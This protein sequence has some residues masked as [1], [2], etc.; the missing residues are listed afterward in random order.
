[1][2]SF[3]SAAV[4]LVALAAATP[5]FAVP[6]TVSETVTGFANG[7]GSAP[8]PPA[9]L[10]L[11]IV[12]PFSGVLL[13]SPV[14]PVA[15][16]VTVTAFGDFGSFANE[17]LRLD[18]EGSSPGTL[19]DNNP[20]ND[21]YFNNLVFLDRGEEY[22]DQPGVLPAGDSASFGISEATFLSLITDGEIDIDLLF[23]AGVDDLPGGPEEFVTVSVTYDSV[24]PEPSTMVLGFAG[25][26]SLAGFRRRRAA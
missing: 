3:L 14:V 11:D 9:S 20:F 1:M 13:P 23:G 22:G 4:C 5:A 26:A 18:L 12:A 25:V 19:F 2:R 7:I 24:I 16:I 10:A 8:P 17:N 6:V 21:L 15:A